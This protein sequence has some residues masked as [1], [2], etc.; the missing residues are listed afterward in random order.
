MVYVQI[1]QMFYGLQKNKNKNNIEIC[2]IFCGFYNVIY[3]I[4]EDILAHN[5][6]G[7]IVCSFFE[8]NPIY[9]RSLFYLIHLSVILAFHE[10]RTI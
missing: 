6:T 5:F 3:I 8:K 1:Y 10:D 4:I 2:Q 7:S 9:T